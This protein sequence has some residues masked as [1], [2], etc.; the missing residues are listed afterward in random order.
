MLLPD[1]SK[2]PLDIVSNLSADN[3]INTIKNAFHVKHKIA[4]YT[5]IL[6]SFIIENAPK[7]ADYA[8]DLLL[9]YNKG[10]PVKTLSEM[11][12]M[13]TSYIYK[14]LKK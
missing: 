10:I 4:P 11:Y 3:I 8:K 5:T 7:K 12:G 6:N 1:L 9:M 14:L 13:S 2:S